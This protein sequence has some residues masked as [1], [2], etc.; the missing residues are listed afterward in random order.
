MSDLDDVNE[1][2][3]GIIEQ[4]RA[5]DG[6]VGPPFEGAPLLILHSTGAKSG[7][8]RLAPIVFQP[9]DEAWAVFA[10]KAGAP[11]NPDWYHNLVANPSAKIELGTEDVAVTARV[12]EGDE[13]S[14]IWEKQKQLM[15][16]FADYEAKTD[17]VIPVVLLERS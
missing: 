16:G 6:K 14:E 4:F 1:F 17:R 10:S 11:D 8:D 2:N 15:P 13:R 12:L 3:R 9:V 5:N 7:K